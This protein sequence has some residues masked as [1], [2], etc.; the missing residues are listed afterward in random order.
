MGAGFKAGGEDIWCSR[1]I[2]VSVLGLEVRISGVV[3]L[4]V[5]FKVGG[6]YIWVSVLRLE[7]R[8]SGVAGIFGCLCS[9][10]RTHVKVGD[11]SF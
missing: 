5:S 10:P 8:I 1:D 4:G 3:G 11:L 6:E 9:A 7:V 2:W